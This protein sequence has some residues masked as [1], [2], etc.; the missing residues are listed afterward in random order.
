[1]A[2]T[3]QQSGPN[4]AE[5]AATVI[6][7]IGAHSSRP[8]TEGCPHPLVARLTIEPAYMLQ[9][10]EAETYSD[11]KEAIEPP[12]RPSTVCLPSGAATE[13]RQAILFVAL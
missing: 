4:T 6:V 3:L 1:M 5:A 11:T 7:E 8:Y 12:R 13:M 9:A 10:M 2:S